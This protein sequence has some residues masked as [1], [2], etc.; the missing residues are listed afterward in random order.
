MGWVW[1]SSLL[2]RRKYRHEAACVVLATKANTSRREEDRTVFIYADHYTKSA[3]FV[4]QLELSVEYQ[5]VM[6]DRV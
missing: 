5:E 6:P 3:L 2:P 4:C 1:A